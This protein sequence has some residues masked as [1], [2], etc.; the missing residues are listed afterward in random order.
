MGIPTSL[1]KMGI[2]A[3]SGPLPPPP[4]V[5]IDKDFFYVEALAP[6][7]VVELSGIG[8][9]SAPPSVSLEYST[10]RA[11]WNSFSSPV[12]L[13]NI[14]DKI[15]LR[16]NNSLFGSN[17]S[18]YN[19]LMTSQNSKVGGN[20][21]SLLDK[22]V[23]QTVI[24]NQ[25]CFVN[26][27]KNN[28]NLIDASDLRLSAT[29]LSYYCYYGMF[30]NCSSLTG[31]TFELPATVA[32]N[33]CCTNMFSGCEALKNAPYIS[34][35]NAQKN[36]FSYMFYNCSSL[37]DAPKLHATTLTN[38]CYSNMFARCTALSSVEVD[39]TSWGTNNTAYTNS[40]LTNVASSGVFKC[41]SN[42]PDIRGA[43]NIPTNWSI[44][45]NFDYLYVEAL[46]NN[47]EIAL[48]KQG[49]PNEIS[50]EYST[51]K[52]TWSSYTVGDTLT[53]PNIGDK[54]YFRGRNSTF[55]QDYQNYYNFTMTGETEIGGRLL[56]L[57]SKNTLNN[58]VSANLF[59]NLFENCV[60][61]KTAQKLIISKSSQ[62]DS[63]GC[64]SLFESCSG[65][66]T[67]PTTINT[68]FG[69]GACQ[70]MFYNCTSLS[71][72]P[73]LPRI[74]LAERCYFNMFGNCTS[75]SSVPELP[76]TSP[77][78]NCYTYMFDGC[79]SLTGIT[80]K[81]GYLTA[82]CCIRMLSNC[83]SLSS[84][85][86]SFTDWNEGHDTAG[87]LATVAENGTFTCNSLLDTTTRDASHVP[88]D[89]TVVN[90]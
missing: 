23:E 76:A 48:V 52:D 37:T 84:V 53:L 78:P 34:A 28:R 22:E 25:M 67:P 1:N 16:G 83:T 43:S 29:S 74:S 79:T 64:A 7:D 26:F 27:F 50:L 51:D 11:V 15:Y 32:V 30:Q 70:A 42:L 46:E 21:M 59:H 41:S 5:P 77:S 80:I 17:T 40:W 8:S 47:D 39:F 60:K 65:L 35:T 14:G 31:A 24:S 45:D 44:K 85:T 12:T 20:I 88:V 18:V 72:I 57:T 33:Y 19:M 36:C 62:I 49:S 71:S 58:Y 9:T 6:N 73:E 3:K 90:S 2:K 68:S 38:G 69:K 4:P 63:Y 56:S 61:L 75:L 81:L 82:G 10:D 87:W 55:C 89:W 86:V 13:S 54:I 66:T